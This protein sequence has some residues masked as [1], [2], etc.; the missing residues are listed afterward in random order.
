[1][2]KFEPWQYKCGLE[3]YPDIS[4]PSQMVPTVSLK[5]ENTEREV[6]IMSKQ[7]PVDECEGCARNKKL[8][9]EVILEPRFIFESYGSC[10]AR[11]TQEQADQIEREIATRGIK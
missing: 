8:K 4:P 9:C 2:G 10:F 7:Y 3:I 6:A 1:M 11:V 5:P